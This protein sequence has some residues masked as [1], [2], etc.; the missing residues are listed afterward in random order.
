MKSSSRSKRRT[1]ERERE[2]YREKGAF[3]LLFSGKLSHD[4]QQF[5][6]FA[7]YLAIDNL[8]ILSNDQLTCCFNLGMVTIK[9]YCNFPSK[10]S[11][12]RIEKLKE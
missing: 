1:I 2:S 8:C 10:K 7:E 9:G 4:M 12:N 5:N 11:F 3:R 6:F